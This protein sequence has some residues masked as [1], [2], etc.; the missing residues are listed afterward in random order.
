V[1]KPENLK[2]SRLPACDNG[3]QARIC[4]PAGLT[5]LGRMHCH[6]MV[7]DIHAARNPHIALLRHII[8]QLL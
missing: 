5:S 3:R 1:A 4:L 2:K 6:P 7:R 8:Q